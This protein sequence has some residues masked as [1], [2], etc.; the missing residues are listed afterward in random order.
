M[1]TISG[2]AKA[3]AY[4]AKLSGSL[5]NDPVVKVG[6][7]EGATYPDGTPVAAVAAFNEFGV[8]RR[9][10][11]PRPFFRNMIQQKGPTWS[12]AIAGLMKAHNNDVAKVLDLTGQAVAGQLRQSI[13]DLVDPPLAPST[14]ARKGN[15]KPLVDTGHMLNSVD[16][17]VSDS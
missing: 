11:P 4:L 9:G 14:V 17:E 13:V 12:A 8:P 6:F 10:Q 15:A 16:Y 5:K 2:G 1:A 3:A 7:L